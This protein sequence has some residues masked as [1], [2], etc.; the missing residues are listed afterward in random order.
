M[1]VLNSCYHIIHSKKFTQFFT[2][3]NTNNDEV[4]FLYGVGKNDMVDDDG[5]ENDNICNNDEGDD[6]E[7][8]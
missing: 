4:G 8:A 7:S 6:N 1:T 2:N 5:G 3:I